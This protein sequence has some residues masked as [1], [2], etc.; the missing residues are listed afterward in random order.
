MII[1][2]DDGREFELSCQADPAGDP[3]AH[4]RFGLK[5]QASQF[6]SLDRSDLAAFIG[7]ARSALSTLEWREAEWI[8]VKSYG[9]KHHMMRAAD[10]DQHGKALCGATPHAWGG[11]DFTPL[12]WRMDKAYSD[13]CKHCFAIY[14]AAIN[15]AES[16]ATA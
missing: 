11:W 10:R 15:A 4:L 6:V 13:D 5:D 1:T 16:E 12:Y 7:E 3:I 14:R 9:N 8:I 2:I